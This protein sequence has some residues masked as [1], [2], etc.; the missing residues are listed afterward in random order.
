VSVPKSAGP[1]AI[2]VVRVRR[3]IVEIAIEHTCI[4]T[5]VPVATRIRQTFQDSALSSDLSHPP[6]SQPQRPSHT[7]C[8]G[9][10][11]QY[12]LPQQPN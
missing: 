2:V 6:R 8:D 1:S 4:R 10:V 7:R 9:G 11:D 3:G 12:A 5:V